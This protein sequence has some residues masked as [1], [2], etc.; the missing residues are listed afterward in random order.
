MTIPSLHAYLTE[1]SCICSICLDP[2]EDS[3]AKAPT[4]LNLDA[5]TECVHTLCIKCFSTITN[6]KCPECR[7]P[8]VQ[9]KYIKK[10]VASLRLVAMVKEHWQSQFNPVRLILPSQTETKP[11]EVPQLPTEIL[12]WNETLTTRKA[13]RAMIERAFAPIV[14]NMGWQKISSTLRE[15]Y[16]SSK[17]QWITLYINGDPSAKGIAWLERIAGC[18]F[19]IRRLGVT[20]DGTEY[21]RYL[22]NC[23]IKEIRKKTEMYKEEIKLETSVSYYFRLEDEWEQLKRH[24]QYAMRLELCFLVIPYKD[25]S[26]LQIFPWHILGDGMDLEVPARLNSFAN[27]QR[28]LEEALTGPLLLGNLFLMS[29]LGTANPAKNVR[30]LEKQFIDQTE[31]FFVY[32]VQEQA[33]GYIKVAKTNARLTILNIEMHLNYARFSKHFIAQFFET[34]KTK[35]PSISSLHYAIPWSKPDSIKE[36]LLVIA[37]RLSLPIDSTLQGEMFE[38]TIQ[39]KS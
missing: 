34:I 21:F 19:K 20:A 24:V 4:R 10:D 12:D 14:D 17:D 3:P 33:M 8:F 2:Y 39:L 22:F 6:R 23:I 29:C 35:C 38:I 25:M 31:N 26:I 27:T 11:L 15:E 37:Q 30:A 9:R 5:E 16:N 36:D 7:T 1:K 28:T 18:M 13:H 32:K